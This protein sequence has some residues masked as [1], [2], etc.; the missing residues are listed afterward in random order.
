M[1]VADAAMKEENHLFI[2]LDGVACHLQGGSLTTR[3]RLPS[4]RKTQFTINQ[5]NRLNWTNLMQFAE[6]MNVVEVIHREQLLVGQLSI[7]QRWTGRLD[8]LEASTWLLNARWQVR[9][10]SGG[11]SVV[12][13]GG[14]VA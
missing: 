4:K 13:S 1:K 9:R 5:H 14:L 11:A 12:R 8:G 2:K 7:G 6:V 3:N 10:C